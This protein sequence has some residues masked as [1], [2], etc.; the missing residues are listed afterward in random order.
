MT[1]LS[2]EQGNKTL[3]ISL[4]PRLYFFWGGGGE[5]G[6]GWGELGERETKKSMFNYIIFILS[7]VS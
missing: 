6:K 3:V 5:G 2:P 1:Y 4:K 7:V